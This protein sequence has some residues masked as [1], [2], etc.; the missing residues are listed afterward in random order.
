MLV[1]LIQ[2]CVVS[3][4]EFQEV[5]DERD[6]LQKELT[7]ARNENRVLNDS[8]DVIYREREKLA[9]ELE[10]LKKRLEELPPAADENETHASGIQNNDRTN[11]QQTQAQ[12]GRTNTTTAANTSRDNNA[13]QA[14]R[15][16]NQTIRYYY[17]N[18]KDT[19]RDVARRTGI[20]ISRLQSLNGFGAGV[21]LQKGQ[22]IRIE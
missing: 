19:L 8:I 3:K 5:L 2:G 9:A 22:R 11:E 14:N 15:T 18:P 12:T 6:R 13:G 20:P 16:G 21:P 17:A 1:G 10:D 4:S 7:Q